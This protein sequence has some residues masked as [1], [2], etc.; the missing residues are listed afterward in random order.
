L[1][2]SIFLAT[3]HLIRSTGIFIYRRSRPIPL[4][5]VIFVDFFLGFI[6]TRLSVSTEGVAIV[7][8]DTAGSLTPAEDPPTGIK[9]TL[10][11]ASDSGA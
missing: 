2:N 10:G 1:S 3:R 9:D 5:V 8:D 6:S 4:F 7:F 11:M